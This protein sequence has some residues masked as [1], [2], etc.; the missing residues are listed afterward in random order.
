MAQENL[1]RGWQK[2]PSWWHAIGRNSGT[3]VVQL[4]TRST[5]VAICCQHH[6]VTLA[7]QISFFFDA[8]PLWPTFVQD[9]QTAQSNLVL[10]E[11]PSIVD[12]R[13][14]TEWFGVQW[15][16]MVH[17]EN[18]SSH[19]DTLHGYGK[20]EWKRTLMDLE[21]PWTWPTMTFLASSIWLGGSK[22]LSWSWAT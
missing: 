17:S 14:P 1:G 9:T 6:L 15:C 18:T 13:A 8:M 22:A 20:I 3:H 16:A 21:R 7:P 4:S 2:L 11:E 5:R 10:L 19:L 12:Y